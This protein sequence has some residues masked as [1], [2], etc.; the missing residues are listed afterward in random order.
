MII[1]FAFLVFLAVVAGS[2]AMVMYRG[3]EG[4]RMLQERLKSITARGSKAD[5][6]NVVRDSRYSAIPWFDA[7]L[8]KINVGQ[9]LELMLYQAGMTMRVGALVLLMT[10]FGFGGYFVG[11]LVMHRLAPALLFMV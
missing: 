7:A 6:V 8:R 4:T 1:F 9:Q 3:G 2:V 5:K 11:V 10:G